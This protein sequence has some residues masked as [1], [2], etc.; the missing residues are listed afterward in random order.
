MG[1]RIATLLLVAVAT[2]V[3][4]LNATVNRDGRIVGGK[5]IDIRQAPYQVVL[6]RNGGPFCGGKICEVL[7]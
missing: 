3:S 4:S 6:L 2:A 5:A 1:V 7:C